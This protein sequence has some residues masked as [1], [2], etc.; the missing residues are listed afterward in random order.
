VQN[1][2]GLVNESAVSIHHLAK[3]ARI[4]GLAF[5]FDERE[6][7]MVNRWC[8]AADLCRNACSL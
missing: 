3:Q 4:F 7:R 8:A 2:I 1:R 5:I 6:A